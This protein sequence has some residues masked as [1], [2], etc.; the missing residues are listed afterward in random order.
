[1]RRLPSIA[2]LVATGLLAAGVLTNVACGGD[3]NADSSDQTETAHP[4]STPTTVA[5]P[6]PV[7]DEQT[8]KIASRE[9]LRAGLA[10]DV[11]EIEV[12]PRTQLRVEYLNDTALPHN[13]RFF[14]GENDTAQ[15]LANTELQKGPGKVQVLTLQAPATPGPYL[16][17]CD[18]HPDQM[19]GFLV[20]RQRQVSSH[21]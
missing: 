10:F 3:S 11:T 1:M 5:S 2:A 6:P 21:R 19:R 13:I 18:V 17:L 8:V 4:V 14:D 20:V 16:F 9:D 15:S 7:S 12:A